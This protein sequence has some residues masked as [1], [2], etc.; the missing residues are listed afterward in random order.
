MM[1]VLMKITA[2]SDGERSL[3]IGQHLPKLWAKIE[4]PDIFYLPGI[5]NKQAGCGQSHSGESGLRC[6]VIF[7]TRPRLDRRAIFVRQIG[8][9]RQ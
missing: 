3:K 8:V 4:C 2:E 7:A 9:A 5:A 1:T 6:V